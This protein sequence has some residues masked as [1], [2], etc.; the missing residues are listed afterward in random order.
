[1]PGEIRLQWWREVLSGEREGEG[2]AHPVAAAL[3][4]SLKQYAIAP[5]R[6]AAIVDAH[7]FDLYDEPL[8]TLDDLDNYAVMTQS[9]LLDVAAD[10]LA[11]DRTETMMLIRSAGIAYTVAG[12]LSGVARHAARGQVYIPQEVLDRHNVTR[13]QVLARQDS[14]ALKTALAELRRHAR[15]QLAAA[16][17][18]MVDAPAAML[19]ALLPLALVGPALRPMERRGYEPFDVPPLSLVKRQWLLWRAARD[20]SRIFAA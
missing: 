7:T 5:D 11:A 13:E 19:P 6:L 2:A 14:D 8:P 3:M 12:I 4:A 16:Q 9:A 1:M 15:R 17:A 20:P 18:D 10:I